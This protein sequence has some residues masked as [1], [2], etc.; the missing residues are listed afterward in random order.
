M[1]VTLDGD[2]GLSQ[3]LCG[4]IG[5]SQNLCGDVGVCMRS[6]SGDKH[7][8]YEQSHPSSEWTV[9][10]NLHKYPAV[11]ITDTA[12]TEVIGEVTYI[13]KDIVVIRFAADVAGYASFN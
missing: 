13:D 7:Y 5:L 6:S 8:F 1:S 4:D 10:H 3:N 9:R 12:Y 2:I 11:S